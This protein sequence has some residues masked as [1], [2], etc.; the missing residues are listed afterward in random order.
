M[1][2]EMPENNANIAQDSKVFTAIVAYSICSSTLL[3]ANK[4]VMLHLPRP[5]IVNLMQIIFSLV[6]MF[7]LKIYGIG[8]DKLEW[9][10]AKS[11]IIYVCAFTISRYSNMKALQHSNV[12]TVIVFRACAPLAVSIVEYMFLG[13]SFPSVRS[14]ISLTLVC[15]GAGIYCY[16]DSE[17]SM[18]GLWAYSWVS[19]YFVLLIFEMTYCK[20]LTSSAKMKSNWGPVFY[21]NFLAAFPT[22]LLV[23]FTGEYKGLNET[24]LDMSLTGYLVILFSCIGGTFIG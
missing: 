21:C 17:F 20:K 19:T 14:C 8:I 3:L 24:Y 6:A 10:K 4:T 9:G 7:G 5:A 11:Y 23:Y 18:H 2:S 22:T 13:R 12:E 16:S 15:L 1:L